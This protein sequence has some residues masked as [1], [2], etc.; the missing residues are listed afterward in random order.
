MTAH[1]LV[2]GYTHTKLTTKD[3]IVDKSAKPAAAWS[4]DQVAEE[5][6]K[7]VENEFFIICPD[8][9]VSWELDQARMQWNLDDVLK[10]RPALSRWHPEHK[11]A[12][13]AYIDQTVKK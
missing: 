3:G 13:A 2:P 12:F 8:N 4:A 11:D 6:F 10:K 1:L 9:D 5:L 7:R